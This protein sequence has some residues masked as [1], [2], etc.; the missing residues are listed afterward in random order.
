[1]ELTTPVDVLRSAAAGNAYAVL[2]D[3]VKTHDLGL[4][5]PPGLFFAMWKASPDIRSAHVPDASFVSRVRISE[6]YDVTMPYPGAPDLAVEVVTVTETGIATID[7]VRDYLKA[8][9]QQ[10]WVLYTSVKEAHIYHRDEP[11]VVRV[12]QGEDIIE[13]GAPLDGL[14]VKTSDLFAFP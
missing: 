4:V 2:R 12:Y 3:Y 6:I 7:K 1:M 9:T 14:H 13:I 11:K 5:F 10:V 8:G